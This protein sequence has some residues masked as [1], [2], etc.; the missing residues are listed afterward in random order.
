MAQDIDLLGATYQDV[1]AVELPKTGGGT[2]LF[3][4]VS[5]TTAAAADVASGK[6]FYTASGVKTAGTNS[7]GGGIGTLLTTKSLGAIS[8]S[9]TSAT[10]TGQTVLVSSINS[11]DLLIVETSVDSVVNNRH[12][13]TVQLIVLTA[14]TNVTT[15]KDGATLVSNTQN[16]KISSSGVATSRQST[17]KYGIYVNSTSIGAAGLTLTMYERYNSTQT[18]TVNG[19]YTVRV[20][21]V[22]TYGLIGG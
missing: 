14:G 17:T 8:T 6:Y 19:R 2:A 20:Y 18:G 7:G 5:D 12:E 11:Y 1:P 16:I 22:S 15:K 21:G 13:A 10:D 9:S 4:D 3:S